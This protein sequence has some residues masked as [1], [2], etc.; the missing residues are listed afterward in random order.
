MLTPDKQAYTACRPNASRRASLEA[1]SIFAQRRATL[2]LRGETM[3]EKETQRLLRVI[4]RRLAEIQLRLEEIDT[5][6]DI[7]RADNMK[8]V[9]DLLNTPH[10]PVP[11]GRKPTLIVNNEEPPK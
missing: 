11:R 3:S 7:D 5:A 9:G 8:A 10:P 6:N 2:Q 1:S 4:L